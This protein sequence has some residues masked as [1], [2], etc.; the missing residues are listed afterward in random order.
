MVHCDCEYHKSM[1]SAKAVGLASLQRRTFKVFYN[2]TVD[3]RC[4]RH[5]HDG[6]PSLGI[7]SC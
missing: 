1:V 6:L 3:H 4:L 5:L 7:T 2:Q